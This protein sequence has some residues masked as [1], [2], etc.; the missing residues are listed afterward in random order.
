[1][2]ISDEWYGRLLT[3]PGIFLIFLLIF[4]PVSFLIVLAFLRYNFVTPIA[5]VGFK[6]FSN[7]FS[8]RLLTHSLKTTGI[9]TVG[10][11]GISLIF[12]LT[13]AYGL[14][15]LGQRRLSTLYRT[16]AIL[17]FAVPL[18]LSGLI[19]RWLLDPAIGVMNY[20][21]IQ[22]TPFSEPI[23]I[24]GN[25]TTALLGVILA[26][27]WI[28]IPFMTIFILAAMDGINQN[29]YEAATIDGATTVTK[30]FYIT[31]P[32]AR[33]GIL[34]GVLITA[35]FSFR[36][37]DAIWSMT[38][39]GPGKATYHIGIYI[40]DRM[41]SLMHLGE[42]AVIGIIV[43]VCISGFAVAMLAWMRKN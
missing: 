11:T 4:L 20:L 40:L 39:G 5:F 35:M 2:K 16:L 21:V 27:A 43:F 34:Y 28:K 32:L 25:S 26:D 33:N 23:N 3:M 24:F 13:I 38:R 30:F 29:L 22:I 8:D 17:P 36:T 18:V 37:I 10:V 6:N 41:L 14:H 19:W 15:R 9:Y 7:I 12:A 1:M 31:L 42:A